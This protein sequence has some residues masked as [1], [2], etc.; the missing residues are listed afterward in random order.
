M[1]RC[2]ACLFYFGVRMIKT[3]PC[4]ALG[5]TLHTASSCSAWSF[6]A[7]PPPCCMVCFLAHSTCLPLQIR[8]DS[9]K[10]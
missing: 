8:L 3:L 10:N 9:G 2:L 7:P 6:W 4:Q 1:Y 5:A